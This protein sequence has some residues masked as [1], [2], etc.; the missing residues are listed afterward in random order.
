[1]DRRTFLKLVGAAAAAFG[2]GGGAAVAEGLLG[3]GDTLTF[4]SLS[5]AA[6][7]TAAKMR[8]LR[9]A[10]NKATVA[11]GALTDAFTDHCED[12]DGSMMFWASEMGINTWE[13]KVMELDPVVWWTGDGRVY[14]RSE[15]WERIDV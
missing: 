12:T 4:D 10:T 13:H 9:K 3:D 1:M 14:R 6:E 8:E 11:V 5:I 7:K 2:L 15:G